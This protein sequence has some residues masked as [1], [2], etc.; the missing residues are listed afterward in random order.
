MWVGLGIVLVPFAILAAMIVFGTKAPP[1]PLD[2][3]SQPFR[4]VDFSDLPPLQNV[5][6]RDGTPLAYRVWPASADALVVIAI[7][8]S[9]AHSAS[10]HPLGKGLAA[11]GVTV[12]APDMRGHGGSGPH[13][14]IG[15]A[16]ELDDDMADFVAAVRA[17]HPK[18]KLALLGFSSGGGFALHIAATPL[19][20]A[21]E[22][23][24]LLSPMLGPR[25]PTARAG[26]PWVAVYL[27]RII[28]LVLLN[29]VGIHAFDGLPTLAFAIAPDNPGK[30][31]TVYSF[32]LM[33][34]FGTRDYAADLRNTQAPL[35]VL[36]GAKDELFDA[37]KFAPA[38]HAV[39]PEVPVTVV[40][41]L[42]H[43]AMT[44]DPRALPAIAAAVR[45]AP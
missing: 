32:R 23:A 38:V 28:A 18:S 33:Q 36:V 14:D 41:E 2:S 24:V 22:R 37:E 39:R 29:R 21:F 20:R 1:P 40:P 4:H 42:G 10:M 16:G 9:S 5:P 44:I 3:I 17:R 12:Y 45:G 35:A 19:G 15:Y 25:A 7:H 30:L 11:A 43:I 27:P 31:T 13:G 6:A 34:A 26:N 8:G